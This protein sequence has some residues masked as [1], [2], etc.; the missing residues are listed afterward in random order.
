VDTEFTV[1]MNEALLKKAMVRQLRRMQRW[2]IWVVYAWIVILFALH[3]V[4]SPRH[5]MTLVLGAGVL[6]PAIMV[7]S[8]YLTVV[9]QARLQTTKFG[10]YEVLYRTTEQGL[11]YESPLASGIYP[12]HVFEEMRRFGD[13]WLLCLGRMQ[14]VALPTD[15]L[16]PEV[17]EFIEAKVRES[18]GKV[19]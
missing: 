11:E 4:V 9:R 12:W 14:S 10:E 15:A 13:M 17:R 3:L 2:Y 18:G 1:Q 8:M 6:I 7:I 5:W 16:A 19:T